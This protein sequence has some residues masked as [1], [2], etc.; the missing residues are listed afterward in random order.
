MEL[1]GAHDW[2]TLN[3]VAKD[4]GFELPPLGEYAVGMF[5]LPTSESRREQSKIVFTKVL[6]LLPTFVQWDVVVSFCVLI[7]V[8]WR[9]WLLSVKSCE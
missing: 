2:F 3:Q 6:L 4:V 5:F 9:I 8:S 1:K 7:T